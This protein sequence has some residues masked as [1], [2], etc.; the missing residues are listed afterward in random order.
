GMCDE[1]MDRNGNFIEVFPK[2]VFEPF[3]T[4]DPW[5]NLIFLKQMKIFK[6]M[7][8]PELDWLADEECDDSLLTKTKWE[9]KEYETLRGE[10]QARKEWQRLNPQLIHRQ[11]KKGRTARR[12]RRSYEMKV[13]RRFQERKS[14]DSQC[15]AYADDHDE[16]MLKVVLPNT[17]K[18]I[19]WLIS[20]ID[21]N[22]DYKFFVVDKSREIFYPGEPIP[23]LTLGYELLQ[24][25]APDRLMRSASLCTLDRDRTM[26]LARCRFDGG[27]VRRSKSESDLYSEGTHLNIVKRD[28]GMRIEDDM[29]LFIQLVE[30]ERQDDNDQCKFELYFT[31]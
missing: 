24:F 4:W 18:T 29:D 3:D 19:F 26:E 11:K 7:V 31:F 30:C 9:K 16:K 2:R 12:R 6:D 25:M 22:V 10:R 28:E 5:C 8:V 17:W 15:V 13:E 1:W 21:D 23:K 27:N 14:E 20:F